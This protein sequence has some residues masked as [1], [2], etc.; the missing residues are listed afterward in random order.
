MWDWASLFCKHN[1][2]NSNCV[3]VSLITIIFWWSC[4]FS[5]FKSQ[6]C[7]KETHEREWELNWVFQKVWVTK[8]PWVKIMVGCDGKF[9]MVQCKV[10]NEVD[11]GE[12]LLVP[13]FDSL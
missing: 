12:N 7:I 9:N 13:K 5:I 1:F 10:Y 2:I 4:Q 8:L 6:T 3:N 11:G